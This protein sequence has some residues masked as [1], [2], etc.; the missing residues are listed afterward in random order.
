[1]T[2]LHA[3]KG[4]IEQT[5]RSFITAII[6]LQKPTRRDITR[7]LRICEKSLNKID[8]ANNHPIETVEREDLFE[9]FEEIL[10]AAKQPDLIQKLDEWRDW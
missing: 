2:I 8:A 5:I 7:E 9:L 1:M 3:S 4:L 10:T 6:E